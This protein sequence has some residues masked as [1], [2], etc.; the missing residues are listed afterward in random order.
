LAQILN[1]LPIL[2]ICH[3]FLKNKLCFC[4]KS[5]TKNN[6]T[7]KVPFIIGH[8]KNVM[9]QKSGPVYFAQNIFGQLF[10]SSCGIWSKHAI[11]I[12]KKVYD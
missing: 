11:T 8:N 6:K 10:F 9:A 12:T 7:S 3:N 4:K 1:N 5:C 2:W